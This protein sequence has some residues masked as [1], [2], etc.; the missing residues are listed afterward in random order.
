[1]LSI[2]LALQ[3]FPLATG[4]ELIAPLLGLAVLLG[5]GVFGL[6]RGHRATA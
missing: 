5:G 3:V 1:V 2:I 6:L 4:W